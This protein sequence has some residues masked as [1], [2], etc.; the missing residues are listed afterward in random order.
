MLQSRSIPVPVPKQDLDMTLN[1]RSQEL[2]GDVRGIF[3]EHEKTWGEGGKGKDPAFMRAYCRSR[4]LADLP[5]D[6]DQGELIS[7]AKASAGTGILS[8]LAL[9]IVGGVMV[10]RR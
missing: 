1:T 10:K 8:L 3:D 9:G 5:A 7:V 2:S 4:K 6:N